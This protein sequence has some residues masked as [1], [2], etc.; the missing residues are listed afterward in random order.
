MRIK[1]SIAKRSAAAPAPW[2]GAAGG[3]DGGKRTFTPWNFISELFYRISRGKVKAVKAEDVNPETTLNTYLRD[4]VHLTGTKRMCLEGGCGSCV[5]AVEDVVNGQKLIFAVNSC[6]VSIFSCHGWK[7]HTIEG[8]GGPTTQYHPI[9]KLLAENNGTQCGFCSSGMVMN[10][11]ALHESGPVTKKQLE[12]S[13][14][15]NLCRCTGYRPILSAFKKLASDAEEK[16]PSNDIED[17]VSCHNGNCVEPCKEIC[18]KKNKAG[19]FYKLRDTKWMKVYQLKDL[20]ELLRNLGT[21]TYLLVAGNTARGIYR[22]TE[23][24]NTYIDVTSVT[25]LTSY[26]VEKETLI[27]GGNVTLNKAIDIFR[28]TSE[29]NPGFAY[30]SQ[31]AEHIDLVANVPVRNI[32]T[33]AGN[34]MTKHDHNEFPSDIFLLLETF[35]AQLVIVDSAEREISISPKDFL[36]TDMNKRVI[37]SIILKQYDSTYKFVSYKIMPRAQNTPAVLNAGFLFKL[38]G[39]AVES[40]RIVYG[41]INPNFIH[42]SNTENFL[43]SHNLFDNVVLKQAYQILESELDPDYVLPD[44]RPEFR[45]LLAISLFYKF[46]LSVAPDDLVSPRNKSGRCLLKRPVSKGVQEFG[47]NKKKYPLSEPVIKLEALVQTSGQ[48]QYI[49][50]IPDLPNQLFA[51]FVTAKAPASSRILKVDTSNAFRVSGVVAYFSKDDIPGENNF[52]PKF[53]IFTVQEEIF[54]SGVVQYYHQPIGIIVADNHDVAVAAAELVEVSYSTPTHKPLLTTR[55]VL[56]AGATDRIHH[57]TTVLP[58]RRDND[59]KHVIK[60]NFNIDMQYHF[61]ME[62][63]CCNVV[64]TEDGLDMHPS[65]QWMD[66]CQIAASSALAIPMN[67]CI[68]RSTCPATGGGFGA[69]ISRNTLVSTAAAL[70]AYKLRKPVKMWMPLEANMNVIGKRYPFYVEYDVGVNENGVIQY[71]EAD[72]Y[73]N[74]GVGGNENITSLTTDVFQNCYDIDTWTFSIYRVKT[75]MHA[76][77]WARAPGSMESLGAIESIMEH[78]AY[79]IGVDASDVKMAN[80]NGTKHPKILE[81][82]KEMQTKADIKA[83]KQSIELYNKANRWKKRGISLVPMAWTLEV[84]ANY[85]VWVSIF[86]GDGTVLVSHG[87]IE[88][89]QGINTKKVAQVCAYKFGIPLEKV[90]VGPSYNVIS[91]NSSTTGGSLT[92]EAVCYALIKACDTLLKRLEPIRKKMKNPT[93]KDLIEQCFNSNV[94]LG[95][96]GFYSEDEPG[97]QEYL[98]YGVCATEVKVDILTGQL[99]ILR[100]DIIEDVGNSMSPLIDIGQVEGAFVMGI[101]YYTTEEIIFS[102]EGEILTN[103][104]WNYKVPG[105]K[106]I[107]IDFRISFPQNNPNPVGV[108][109]SKAIAEPPICLSCAIPL[110]IRNALASARTE[111]DPSKPKWY[112]FDGPST[113]ENTL[114]NT[115]NNYNQY[116]L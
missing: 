77:T 90:A 72:L 82:W 109:K 14:S 115:L 37:K 25:E 41:A 106:D 56:R 5:V 18:E 6:L 48:A 34:L 92:S 51:A 96:S 31:M 76:N 95:A 40:A 111:S 13:F 86:H 57:E 3:V 9:Q 65:T 7:I 49:A 15:G 26:S 69:K 54:C 38:N 116:V 83:R 2:D 11:F 105:A 28:R 61:H 4:K 12:N 104:T 52:M 102:D 66:L 32:G 103:R 78:I 22:R 93:W 88:M 67:R 30:M 113:V 89:G 70:A 10:M 80:I 110:A 107:P 43:K 64:P 46:I 108:L 35:E 36:K 97:I 44:S 23:I 85:T 24:P 74:Y 55:D 42:A 94:Q 50:D 63:Q 81:F 1:I 16:V 62:V 99:Q 73:S 91:P 21:N 84:T 100:V 98:I 112:P 114:L 58:V 60:G 17:I 39:N 33:L 71:L 79:S 101:G 75:D 29:K 59:I 19:F 47:T 8:I 68:L 27:L 53:N 45:K 87:G 20:L